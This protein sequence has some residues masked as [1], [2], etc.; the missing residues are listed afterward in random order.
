MFGVGLF[1][2]L[3]SDCPD[4]GPLA[5]GAAEALPGAAV[6]LPGAAGALPGA[7]KGY[8][9][10]RTIWWTRMLNVHVFIECSKC[11][12]RLLPLCRS[13]AHSCKPLVLHALFCSGAFAALTVA[14]TAARATS[15]AR[16]PLFPASS[17]FSPPGRERYATRLT[18]TTRLSDTTFTLRAHLSHMCV[19][20]LLVD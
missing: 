10:L 13:W 5:A 12:T 16:S 20:S 17:S 18:I 14:V 3:V 11:K 15:I 7:A 9:H 6:P 4:A 19:F 2:C 1:R 8:E